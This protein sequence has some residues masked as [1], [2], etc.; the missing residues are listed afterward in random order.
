MCSPPSLI[1]AKPFSKTCCCVAELW[2]YFSFYSSHLLISVLPIY[3]WQTNCIMLYHSFDFLPHEFDLVSQN[4]DTR[5]FKFFKE[6]VCIYFFLFFW[7]SVLTTI[8]FSFQ[9]TQMSPDKLSMS[10]I[11]KH[12]VPADWRKLTMCQ[13]CLL[14]PVSIAIKQNAPLEETHPPP[15]KPSQQRFN[16]TQQAALVVGKCHPRAS[17][18]WVCMCGWMCN[19]T[20]PFLSLMSHQCTQ[21]AS[22]FSKLEYINTSVYQVILHLQGVEWGRDYTVQHLFLFLWLNAASSWSLSNGNP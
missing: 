19:L 12:E 8:S 17:E 10:L 22:A 11:L 4:S 7:A 13:P 9:Q 5:T 21:C 14:C 1:T 18:M 20:V 3:D 16:N 15:Q 6:Q 2:M